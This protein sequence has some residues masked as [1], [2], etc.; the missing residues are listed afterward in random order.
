MR[1]N[2]RLVL[3]R[4]QHLELRATT[5]HLVLGNLPPR[6]HRTRGNEPVMTSMPE[7]MRINRGDGYAVRRLR[8]LRLLLGQ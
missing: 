1:T 4:R 3:D 7:T 5:R 6:A 2:D 8:R